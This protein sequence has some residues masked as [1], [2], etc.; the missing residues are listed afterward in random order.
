VCVYICVRERA[1]SVLYLPGL[2]DLRQDGLLR[3]LVLA[4]DVVF[5]EIPQHAVGDL[6][7]G[8]L[9]RRS[10]LVDVDALLGLMDASLHLFF[11][12]LGV[13][14]GQTLRGR[15]GLGVGK[16][17]RVKDFFQIRQ[18][19]DQVVTGGVPRRICALDV[20]LARF[21]VHIRVVDAAR[22]G[23]VGPHVRVVVFGWQGEAE[24]EYAIGKG[25]PSN[26]NDSV[27]I[28]QRVHRW[29]QIDA[30]GC[31]GFQV[32]VFDRDFVIAKGLLALF[33]KRQRQRRRR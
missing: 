32:F 25:T 18:H 16:V 3:D 29:D 12:G 13:P 28:A 19:R 6:F 9:C 31:M 30:P 4:A 24:L 5:E 21:F 23:N 20:E 10:L 11:V 33:L 22:K 15:V 7:L 17:F 26:E 2:F 1:T 14:F 27:E 8:E